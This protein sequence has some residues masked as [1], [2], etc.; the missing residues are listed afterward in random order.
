MLVYGRER[1]FLELL[2][3]ADFPFWKVVA[4]GDLVEQV[5]VDPADDP[6]LAATSRYFSKTEVSSPAEGAFVVGDV[7]SG[8]T[9][10]FWRLFHNHENDAH[11]VYVPFPVGGEKL[12]F[13]VYQRVVDVLGIFQVREFVNRLANYWGGGQRVY[14]IYRST[15]VQR[16]AAKAYD[17]ELRESYPYPEATKTCLRVI[18][19][20]AADP[21]NR[22]LAERWILAEPMDLRELD[23]LRAPKDLR[24][25][26]VAATMLHLFLNHANLLDGPRRFLL[27]FDELE[28][29]VGG[30]SRLVGEA[31]RVDG[32]KDGEENGEGGELESRGRGQRER[33]E[34]SS[35]VDF[36]AHLLARAR[37]CF[38]ACTC[39]T[40]QWPKLRSL[41]PRSLTREN[42]CRVVKLAGL[43]P[44]RL[45]LLVREKVTRFWR[46]QKVDLKQLLPDKYH[47]GDVLPYFPFTRQQVLAVAEAS[48]GNPREALSFLKR[49]ATRILYD[50]GFTFDQLLANIDQFT[51][52]GSGA[53]ATGT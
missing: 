42:K 45:C 26:R 9:A 47:R 49:I 19:R 51:S 36:V 53:P 12:A 44:E 48:K 14:G 15:N 32:E 27:F 37:N 7:G 52:G 33:K 3:A 46:S 11:L 20:A 17:L 22:Q 40:G 35:I 41:L 5:T 21:E 2:H 39:S 16:L 24:D 23:R 18:C 34:F 4:R 28:R 30:S 6:V 13:Q 1:K 8:K 10:L 43:D 25:D 31:G 29:A 50:E 38:V